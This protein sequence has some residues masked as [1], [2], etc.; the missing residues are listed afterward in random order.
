MLHKSLA[1]LALVA[2]AAPA[3]S[4]SI[5]PR[6]VADMPTGGTFDSPQRAVDWIRED[7]SRIASAFGDQPLSMSACRSNNGQALLILVNSTGGGS[8]LY[9]MQLTRNGYTV[10]HATAAERD[11]STALIN[12]RMVCTHP[13]Q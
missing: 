1:I 12:G 7:A 3:L 10:Q 13:A 9:R 11:Q 8:S 6:P 4:A 5:N 2:V